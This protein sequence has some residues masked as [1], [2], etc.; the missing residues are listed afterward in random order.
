MIYFLMLI[1]KIISRNLFELCA[2]AGH[3][4]ENASQDMAKF[5]LSYLTNASLSYKDT[6]FQTLKKIK[7]DRKELRYS[8]EAKL[9]K[10]SVDAV[11]FLDNI[12]AHFEKN[13]FG[14]EDVVHHFSVDGVIKE[15]ATILSKD[16]EW[17]Q[18][19]IEGTNE[20]I[21]VGLIGTQ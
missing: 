20:Y 2:L 13:L 16:M 19:E 18:N 11:L 17:I 14:R 10:N 15:L 3:V 4:K 21:D 6:I 5:F 7:S 12:I 9:A 1:K 8:Q